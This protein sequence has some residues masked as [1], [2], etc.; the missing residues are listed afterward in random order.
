[1][2]E[3]WYSFPS[4]SFQSREAETW[5]P[6]ENIAYVLNSIDDKINHNQAQLNALKQCQQGFLHQ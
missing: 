2:S 4:W 6:E 5:E 3:N 1:M